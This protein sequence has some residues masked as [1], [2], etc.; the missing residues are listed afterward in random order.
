MGK[1]L[2][3]HFNSDEFKCRDGTSAPPDPKLLRLLEAMRVKV[4]KAIHVNSAYRSDAYNKKV[5]G[6]PGSQHMI[7]HPKN[8]T[9]NFRA[10]DIRID[11]MTPTEVAKLAISLG[12]TGIGIYKTFTHVDVR[13]KPA[14]WNG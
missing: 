6:S 8:P 7:N 14:R 12:F 9:P 13:P 10:A 3:P 1:Q 5:G 4:G 11:G 2:S